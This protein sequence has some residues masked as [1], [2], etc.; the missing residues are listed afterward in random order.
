[1]GIKLT[2]Y[3]VLRALSETTRAPTTTLANDILGGRVP[4]GRILIAPNPLLA[5]LPRATMR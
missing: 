2:S 4:I 5:F 1:M 3:L